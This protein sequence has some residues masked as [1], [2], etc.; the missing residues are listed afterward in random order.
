MRSRFQGSNDLERG[1]IFTV[2]WQDGEFMTSA[3]TTQFNPSPHRAPR[4]RPHGK[5]SILS[6]SELYCWLTSTRFRKE[7]VVSVNTYTSTLFVFNVFTSFWKTWDQNVRQMYFTISNSELK[8]VKFL[9]ILS[10]NLRPTLK[11]ISSM[12]RRQ[13][14]RPSERCS[15]SFEKYFT[16]SWIRNSRVC[17]VSSPSSVTDISSK[18]I[19]KQAL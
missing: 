6:T 7:N 2:N 10:I 14:F 19:S 9:V 17:R 8:R 18:T 3:L 16:D 15:V 11:P 5:A 1:S 12:N 13:V 4:R